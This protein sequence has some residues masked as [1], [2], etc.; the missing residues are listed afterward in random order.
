MDCHWTPLIIHWQLPENEENRTPF[1][2]KDPL[3]RLGLSIIKIIRS[4]DP[5]I[6]IM[7]IPI[8]VRCHL[9]IVTG[10]RPWWHRL[11]NWWQALVQKMAWCHKQT[12][13]YPN[14]CGPRPLM[15][16]YI[17]RDNELTHYM[18]I[19]FWKKVIMLLYS[20]S[21]FNRDMIQ[22]TENSPSRKT[23]NYLAQTSLSQSH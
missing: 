9:C 11:L 22:I 23:R 3:S 1:Q 8:L 16:Y 17:T 12:S 10:P 14:Q 2:Y 19:K 13:H 15:H 4:W 18:P 5:L 20:I 21:F 7:G 6:F